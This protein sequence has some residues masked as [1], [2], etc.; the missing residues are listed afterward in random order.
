MGRR[1]ALIDAVWMLNLRIGADMVPN[2][3]SGGFGTEI[4]F[5]YAVIATV[6]RVGCPERTRC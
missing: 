1:R 2:T 5:D 4:P 3:E 6:I